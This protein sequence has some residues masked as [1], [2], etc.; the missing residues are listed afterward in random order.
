M[1]TPIE[2]MR[3]IAIIAHVDHGKTT[4]VDELLKQSGTF[5]ENEKTAE[6]M[7]D[8]NDLEKERGITILAK[9][10]SVEWNGYRINIVDTPG[11]ADFGGEVERVLNMVD[12]V[13]LLVDAIEG[14]MPQTR[15]VLKKALELNKKVVVVVNKI[16]REGAR[17]DWVVDTTFDLFC[18]LGATDEQT[19]F[20]V[21]YASGFQGIA[22]MEVDA[23]ADNLEPLFD[24]IINEVPP[25]VV[26]TTAPLQMLVTNLDYD[27]FKGRIALGRV[28]AGTINKAQNIKLGVP[29]KDSRNGKIGEVFVY[30]NFQKEIVE[31]VSAGDICAVAG[32]DDVMIGETIM[33]DGAEPLPT[34]TVEEPTV[35]MT[36]SVNG[37]PFA[38][39]EGKFVTSRN[40]KDRLD[41]ELERNLA[42][43]VEPGDTADTFI[44]CG[45]GALHITILIENMRR[46]GFEFCIGPPQVI[47]KEDANGK[48]LEPFEEAIVEVGE[49]YNGSVVEL[50]ANRKGEML[51]LVT[52]DKGMTTIKY[53]VPT[54]GLLGVRNAI[55]TATRGTAV[56]NTIFDDYYPFAG[57]ISQRDQGS[58]IAFETGQATS[59]A[60]FSAQERGMMFIKPGVEV[61]EGMVVGIHQRSGDL[62]VNVAKRKAATNVRSNK[63]ATVVLNEPKTL[64]LDDCVE[65]IGEDELV[66]VTPE[67]VRIL[68][69]PKMDKKAMK[70]QGKK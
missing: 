6:R 47:F 25:P 30:K 61:Y 36:F 7:M 35:R 70:Q 32:L 62:K 23:M 3:N 33:A 29:G 9:T 45:R 43:R 40:I 20:P 65:Y 19:D 10:T 55:L 49:E 58:L 8:S 63:D 56:L 28:N 52:N 5:R 48:K 37:S 41:R 1:S 46:E 38:G 2:K 27:E 16:D 39:K 17:P 15:F 34:I 64:S 4:L 12:G 50:L 67:S 57:E 31:E 59:Y 51:D 54:R 21:V 66:E 22:G 60:L 53:K 24:M 42:L 68:K 11:H 44:V 26:N 13:L 18:S 69:N 14:P